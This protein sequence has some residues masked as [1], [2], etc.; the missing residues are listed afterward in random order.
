MD[1]QEIDS[2]ELTTLV[3]LK[4]R[5]D[6]QPHVGPLAL[7]ESD[8]ITMKPAWNSLYQIYKEGA[9]FE[10]RLAFEEKKKSYVF[11]VILS[12]SLQ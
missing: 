11:S 12:K 8:A 2:A 7:T 6:V 5:E 3:K 9:N 4:N 1:I 10:H